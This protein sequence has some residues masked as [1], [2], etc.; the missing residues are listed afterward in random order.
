MNIAL[1]VLQVLLA[2]HTL[3]G[4]IWKFK[5]SAEKTMPTLKAIPPGIWKGLSIF[6]ILCAVG[7]ILPAFYPP[8]AIVVS[9]SAL[10]IAAVLLLFTGM[11]I[12]SGSRAYGP[13]IYW[14]VVASLCTIVAY[15]RYALVPFGQ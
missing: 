8:L 4:A 7:L 1:W 15:G 3:M 13:I 14:L 11:H 6:E 9:L 5:N 10:G 2:L 12:S